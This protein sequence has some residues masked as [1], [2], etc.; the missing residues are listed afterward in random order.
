MQFE[1][2]RGLVM[3]LKPHHDILKLAEEQAEKQAENSN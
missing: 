1:K 2:R 3:R